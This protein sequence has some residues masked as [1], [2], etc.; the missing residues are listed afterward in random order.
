[1][2]RF[3]PNSLFISRAVLIFE[4][5]LRKRILELKEKEDGASP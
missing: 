5:I 3:N 4:A 2:K 1:M